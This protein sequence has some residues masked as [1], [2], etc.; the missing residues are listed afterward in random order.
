MTTTV[1]DTQVI[2]AGS[3]GTSTPVKLTLQGSVSRVSLEFRV[4]LTTRSTAP[5]ALQRP[6]KK[7]FDMY[8]AFSAQDLSASLSTVPSQLRRCAKCTTLDFNPDSTDQQVQAADTPNG[9]YL[10]VWFE[11][12]QS[13]DG[14]TVTESVS[15]FTFL[16][17][18]T[19]T[20]PSNFAP[21]SSAADITLA[22]GDRLF[23]QNL[24]TNPLFVRRGTGATSSL[25]N[26]VLQAA[27]A[28]DD[29]TGGAIIIDD[30]VG[31]VSFAGT[32]VRYNAW[33]A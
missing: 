30:F 22:N 13:L 31:I 8:W 14:Y 20:A 18:Q 16:T 32:S 2:A 17:S 25:F 12:P 29:G 4:R 10:Y 27:G 1:V 19:R 15:E 24:G 9:P 5:A 23:V 21:I 11:Y 26:Y 3:G 28:A 33:K 7:T 6:A